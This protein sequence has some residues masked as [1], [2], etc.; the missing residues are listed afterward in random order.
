[1]RKEHRNQLR[2]N[3]RLIDEILSRAED[4]K[5]LNTVN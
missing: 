4:A 3:R 5:R 2:V 1:M